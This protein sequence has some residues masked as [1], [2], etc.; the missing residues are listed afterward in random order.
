MPCK[1]LCPQTVLSSPGA[2][3]QATADIWWIS[4][5]RALCWGERLRLHGGKQVWREQFCGCSEKPC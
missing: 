1:Y 4:E 5:P 2:C 3:P